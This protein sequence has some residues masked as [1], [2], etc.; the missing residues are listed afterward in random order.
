MQ[1]VAHFSD[2][3]A[4]KLLNLIHYKIFG[5]KVQ[6]KQQYLWYGHFSSWN[7]ENISLRFSADIFPAVFGFSVSFSTEE[8]LVII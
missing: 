5:K 3:L 4:G 6:L 8:K 1:I 2:V 7:H